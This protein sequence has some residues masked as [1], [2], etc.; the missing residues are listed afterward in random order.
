MAGYG[1]SSVSHV[2]RR[3]AD[4]AAYY[5]QEAPARDQRDIDAARRARLEEFAALLRAER[6]T[7]LIEV[8]CGPGHDAVRFAAH[9]LRVVGAD[10]SHAHAQLAARRIG[11]AVQASLF[12]LPFRAASFDAGWTMSTLV[13]VADDEFAAAMRSIVASLRPLSPLAIGLWGGSDFEGIA[14][15]DTILPRRFFSLRTHERARS[16]LAEHGSVERF[17]T[18]SSEAT[19]WQ[20]QFAIVRTPE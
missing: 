16:M 2:G 12:D 17:D 10:L 13:H 14:E 15:F 5:D 19:T 7:R 20:Y 1:R 9:G 4:L 8:G 6:R 11:T 3:Q 18:W